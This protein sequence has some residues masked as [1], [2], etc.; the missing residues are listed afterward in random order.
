M[1]EDPRGSA[2]VHDLGLYRK[3]KVARKTVRSPHG[4][5]QI[6]AKQQIE[7]GMVD[8]TPNESLRILRGVLLLG[9]S[10]LDLWDRVHPG[11]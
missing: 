6:N 7:Y 8:V 10:L 9:I 3:R 1:N 11:E 4:Y 2:D 5:S